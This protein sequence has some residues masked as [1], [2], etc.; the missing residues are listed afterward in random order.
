MAISEIKLVGTIDESLYISFCSQLDTLERAKTK[1]VHIM[2]SSAGG[3]AYDALA[4][5]SRMRL[6]PCS[7][8]VT[9]YGLCASAAV[10]VLAAGDYRRMTR[11]SWVM[12]HE[13]QISKLTARVS[14][15]EVQVR[16]ARSME[17]QWNKLLS[18]RTC[19][20]MSQ[21]A[22][23]HKAERYLDPED[24]QALGLIEEVI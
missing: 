20:S 23:L 16:H 8:T 9:V 14:S 24:C 19:T 5:Y 15:A 13:D 3:A 7:F 4:F 2:L 1:T 10:L 21:W 12:V 17:N 22:Q 18:E 6:S 11:E